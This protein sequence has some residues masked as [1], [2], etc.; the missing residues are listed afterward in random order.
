MDS[1]FWREVRALGRRATKSVC[2]ESV[3]EVELMVGQT[4]TDWLVTVF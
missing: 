1:F 2:F 4:E 3:D